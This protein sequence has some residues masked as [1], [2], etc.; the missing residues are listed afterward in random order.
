MADL[1]PEVPTDQQWVG[2]PRCH[3][4]KVLDDGKI[5]WCR[6]SAAHWGEHLCYCGREWK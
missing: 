6:V 3:M 1:C 2:D 4:E 5:H